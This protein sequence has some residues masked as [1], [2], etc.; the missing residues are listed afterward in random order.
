[1]IKIA[2]Y[3]RKSVEK[4]NSISVENQLEFCKA[5]FLRLHDDCEFFEFK[6]DGYTGANTNRPAFTRMMTLARAKQFDVIASYKLDRIARSTVDYLNIF[7]ELKSLDISLISVSEG[8]DPSTPEGQLM[9][10]M[11]SS[12]AELERQNIAKRVK[13]SMEER[14][15]IGCFSGGTCPTGYEVTVVDFNGKKLKYLKLIPKMKN[16]VK[17]I[18]NL[19]A[20]GYSIGQIHNKLNLPNKTLYNIIQNPTYVET[21]EESKSYLESLGYRVFGELKENHGFLPY[22][23]RQKKNGKKV[24]SSKEKFVA[25][26]IH[27]PIVTSDVFIKANENIKARGQ[28]AKPRISQKT[29]LAH[30][31]KCHCGSGMFVHANSS[32]TPYKDKVYFRCTAQ[33]Q[34][35]TCNSKWLKVKDVEDVFLNTLKNIKLD[36]TLLE[37]YCRKD[38][39]DD[40]NLKAIITEKKKEISKLNKQIDTLVENMSL[41]SGPAVKNIAD[42]INNLSADINILNGELTHL[43]HKE[44]LM[45]S[46]KLDIDTLYNQILYLLDHHDQISLEDMQILA[47][48]IVTRIEYD[49]VDKITLIF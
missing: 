19:A 33:K 47:K 22:N 42:K 9:M 40:I 26:S 5:H 44:I 39:L 6:D 21:S 14:A 2:I 13:D 45:E 8:Y 28:E 15:K 35:K 31:V 20:E 48:S 24:T 30:L 25:V 11:L 7:E 1:M 29:F 43:Q 32:N 38:S 34:K 41:L 3:C 17:E 23:R 49:G 10:K 12:F 18:F 4:E 36:K 37:N 16:R 46:E 27:E